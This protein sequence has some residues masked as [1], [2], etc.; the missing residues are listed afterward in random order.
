MRLRTFELMA[1]AWVGT[2][3]PTRAG[4]E[5]IVSGIQSQGRFADQK[6]A[7]EEVADQ[8]FAMQAAREFG[9]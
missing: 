2:G 4:M 3:V 5:N 9:S 8:R 1:V 7:F 6:V